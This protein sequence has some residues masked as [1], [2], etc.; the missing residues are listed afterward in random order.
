M[1]KDEIHN[2]WLTPEEIQDLGDRALESV[3]RLEEISGKTVRLA[4]NRGTDRTAR[5]TWE[6]RKLERSRKR[7]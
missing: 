6:A 7:K 4:E 2:Y 5:E 1:A 3:A